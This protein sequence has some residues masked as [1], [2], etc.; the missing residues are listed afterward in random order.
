MRAPKVALVIGNSRYATAPLRNPVNDARAVANLLVRL[1]FE[2]T[3]K[4]DITRAQMLAAIRGYT[5]SLATR[6]CM[7]LFYYA[8][9]GAQLA[10]TNYIVPVDAAIER[11]DDVPKQAVAVTGLI[12]GIAKAANPMNVIILDACRDNPFGGD[13]PIRQKGLS[14]MDAPPN[15]LLAYATSPGNVASDGTGANGLYTEYLVREMAVKGAKI[16]DVFK[17]VRLG[18]RRQSD[19]AQIPWESTS[20][21]EDFYFLPSDQLKRLSEEEKTRRFNE[22]LALWRRIQDSQDPAAFED[23]LRR[24]PSGNFAELAQFRLDRVLA[25]RGEKR[26]QITS[27]VGN[28]FTKGSAFARISKVGDTVT[29]RVSDLRTGAER[30]TYTAKVVRVTETE[31]VHDT[32]L[33]SDLLG[34]QLRTTDGYTF[35]PNQLAA[36][37]F[38]VGKRWRTQ[39]EV[40]DP[41]GVTWQSYQEIRIVERKW[42]LTPAGQFNAFRLE[43]RGVSQNPAGAIEFLITRWHVPDFQWPVVREERR[44]RGDQEIYAQRLEMLSIKL[45]DDDG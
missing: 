28:P 12:G 33:V 43:G 20:L 21:E 30:R 13:K 36:P 25:A 17:R 22:E 39:Y 23:Y 15:T 4:R 2:V 37:E 3:E 34:N 32:G 18:V 16:E 45:A 8:G 38:A 31:V 26:I 24:H 42:V 9:H 44:R 19:G 27:Q 5:H 7:G 35:S 10:W 14:Q 11:L 1:G 29:Y 40:T 41:K 6:K